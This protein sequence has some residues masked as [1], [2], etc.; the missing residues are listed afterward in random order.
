MRLKERTMPNLYILKKKWMAKHPICKIEFFLYKGQIS[1]EPHCVWKYCLP[2]CL[3]LGSNGRIQWKVRMCSC[4]ALSL[5]NSREFPGAGCSQLSGTEEMTWKSRK[6]KKK[7]EREEKKTPTDSPSVR[8]WTFSQTVLQF[9]QSGSEN[10]RE[11]YLYIFMC[12]AFDGMTTGSCCCCCCRS[13]GE[14]GEKKRE[15]GK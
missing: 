2:K 9:Q 5:W 14:R 8:S 1:S 4:F 11:I 15:E 7:R 10:R 3:G 13:L 12:L 6:K